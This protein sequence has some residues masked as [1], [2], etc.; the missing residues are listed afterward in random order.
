MFPVFDPTTFTIVEGGLA[1]EVDLV[2]VHKLEAKKL[3]YRCN[4]CGPGILHLVDGV[5]W[6]DLDRLMLPVH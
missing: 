4:D 2:T 1:A 6:E 3:V 5:A